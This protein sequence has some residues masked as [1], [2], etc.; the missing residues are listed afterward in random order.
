MAVKFYFRNHLKKEHANDHA[1]YTKAESTV[2][3]VFDSKGSDRHLARFTAASTISFNQASSPELRAFTSSLN[4]AY[5]L[6]SRGTITSNIQKEAHI[7][8]DLI[9]KILAAAP[10]VSLN[11]K[12]V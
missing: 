8:Q 11:L 7:A 3:W 2:K 1:A 10:M 12:L 9:R 4:P 5:T 6:P